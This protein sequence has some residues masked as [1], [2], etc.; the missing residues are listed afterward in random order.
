MSQDPDTKGY[1]FVFHEKYFEKISKKYHEKHG[2]KY[3]NKQ[4]KWHN[5]CQIDYSGSNFINRTSGSK[6]IDA[7]NQ[8]KQF[9][10]AKDIENISNTAIY[11][12][13]P[14]K[15]NADSN[16]FE[17]NLNEKVDTKFYYNSQNIFDGVIDKVY[18]FIFFFS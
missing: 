9:K 13:E 11:K 5:Q 1:I 4:Y 15:Y 8:E 10:S 17:R 16:I 6:Q 12:N 14:L 2:K 3:T 7:F 18:S